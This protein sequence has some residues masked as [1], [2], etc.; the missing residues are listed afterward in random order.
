MDPIRTTDDRAQDPSPAVVPAHASEDETKADATVQ[1]TWRPAPTRKR[2]TRG[3]SGAA[4]GGTPKKAYRPSS[5]SRPKPA[6][7]KRGG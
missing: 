4:A 3:G 2:T 1:S 6:G 7:K 5:S